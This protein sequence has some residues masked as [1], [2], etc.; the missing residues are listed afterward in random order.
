MRQLV[1][2]NIPPLGL[3]NDL[4]ADECEVN[5][6]EVFIG[7]LDNHKDPSNYSYWDTQTNQAFDLRD[8]PNGK[9]LETKLE[10]LYVDIWHIADD[11]LVKNPLYRD[12]LLNQ[13]WE[14]VDFDLTLPDYNPDDH[15]VM[16]LTRELYE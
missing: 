7:A 9:E 10:K 1:S 4:I 6:I 8:Y 16:F 15:A 12:A 13:N 11:W 3:E 14:F 2:I 5:L